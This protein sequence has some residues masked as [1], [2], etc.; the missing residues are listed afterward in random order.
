M[1]PIIS[2]CVVLA[3]SS[4][5]IGLLLALPPLAALLFLAFWLGHTPR[6]RI[7][8]Y[9]AACAGCIAFLPFLVHARLVRGEWF[10]ES[11]IA[12]IAAS[13]ITT[14]GAILGVGI[15]RVMAKVCHLVGRIWR[16]S[17]R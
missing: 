12:P 3:A 13:A 1:R 14:L 5:P 6:Q 11:P 8:I 2:L 16:R 10:D 17:V 7:A 9:L 4:W 15:L